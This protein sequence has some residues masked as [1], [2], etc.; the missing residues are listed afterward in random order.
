VITCFGVT[1][2]EGDDSSG[3]EIASA[4]DK[5]KSTPNMSST[6]GKIRRD[7]VLIR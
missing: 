2:G 3:V 6:P 5:V 4:D 1:A 7:P